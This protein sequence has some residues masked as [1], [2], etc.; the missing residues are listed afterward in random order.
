[1]TASKKLDEPVVAIVS[2]VASLAILVFTVSYFRNTIFPSE[3]LKLEIPV[4]AS[5]SSSRQ[6]YNYRGD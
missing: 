2:K 6:L 3:T 5:S 4:L 1:M